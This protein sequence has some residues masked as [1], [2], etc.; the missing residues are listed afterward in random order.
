MPL[1]HP[2]VGVSSFAT[3]GKYDLVRSVGEECVTD[4]ELAMLMA[5]KPESFVLYDGFEPSGRMHIAQVTRCLLYVY[6]ACLSTCT[7]KKKEWN[8]VCVFVCRTLHLPLAKLQYTAGLFIYHMVV[9][10]AIAGRF[11]SHECQQVHEGR[12]H[13]HLLGG[14]LVCAHE[15]QDGCVSPL[16]LYS[17]NQ[18]RII[19]IAHP[20]FIFKTGAPGK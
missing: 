3:Q 2:L 10:M 14:R 8:C 17:S 19:L 7:Q 15:R 6:G 12:W 11:Q 4:G 18:D 13:F 9:R 1:L 16:F 20:F 5:R